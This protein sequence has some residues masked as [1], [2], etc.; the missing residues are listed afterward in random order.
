L[1]TDVL[2]ISTYLFNELSTFH[3]T[4]YVRTSIFL[5]SMARVYAILREYS[6]Q[7]NH[8]Y[9]ILVDIL[10]LLPKESDVKSYL[11]GNQSIVYKD[12]KLNTS[13]DGY[14]ICKDQFSQ[15]LQWEE[16]G[17]EYY[18]RRLDLFLQKEA[19]PFD[20]SKLEEI[21]K[22]RHT[23]HNCATNNT[24]PMQQKKKR[25]ISNNNNLSNIKTFKNKKKK[26]S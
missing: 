19:E 8:L 21:L 16:K 3:K 5:A 12:V 23:I 25:T 15:Y 24:N 7:M 18:A 1:R 14:N 9:N 22:Q 20:G 10:A 2:H 11:K 6:Y 13:L 4:T 17:K 26:K